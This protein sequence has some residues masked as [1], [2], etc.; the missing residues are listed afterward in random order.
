MA[1]D[2][3]IPTAEIDKVPYDAPLSFPEPTKKWINDH[4]ASVTSE[5]R[6]KIPDSDVPGTYIKDSHPQY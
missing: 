6:V 1:S 5:R 2:K 3:K 4:G